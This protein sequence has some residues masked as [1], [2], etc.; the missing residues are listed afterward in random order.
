MPVEA[1]FPRSSNLLPD[2]RAAE[3][4][5]LQTHGGDIVAELEAVGPPSRNFC[6]AGGRDELDLA[7]Q[8]IWVA[9]LSHDCSSF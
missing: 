7:H 9:A 1:I 8:S 6:L 3:R 5:P 2:V 4:S